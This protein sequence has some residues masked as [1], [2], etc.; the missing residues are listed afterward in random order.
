MK[1]SG[2]A[3]LVGGRVAG[4]VAGLVAALA[5]WMAGAPPASANSV[6]PMCLTDAG[7]QACSGGW[8]TS[9]VL[10]NWA[11]SPLTA[12]SF[13]TPCATETLYSAD[14]NTTV[15]C[16][17]SWPS[18]PD[19]SYPYTMQVELSSPAAWAVP[20]RPPDA[21]GW[22]HRP[23]SVA[24]AGSAFSGIATC[25]QAAYAGPAAASAVITGSCTDNAGKTASATL[26][27]AYDATPPVLSAT[28]VTGDHLVS[29]RWQASAAPAPLASVLISRTP[30]RRTVVE[31]AGSGIF[32]DTQVKD[33]VRY[34]YTI[35]AIDQAGNETVL[36]VSGVPAPRLLEPALGARVTSAP[37]LSW[38]PVRGARYY[39]VQLTRGAREIFSA[40]PSASQLALGRSWWFGG[41][42]YRLR[43]GHYRWYVWPGLGARAA[44][45]YGPLIGQGAFVLVRSGH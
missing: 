44:D 14:T 28:P 16:S 19:I 21:G 11:W 13:T 32:D 38:T 23:L 29:V 10:L 26:T 33:H 34:R 40:W 2:V 41:L 6:T 15:T 42:R 37:L 7:L 24:F 27:I 20:S 35:T 43:P 1:A 22:Y 31:H 5:L 8:Y 17:V 39:N 18:P 36:T 9:P 12:N 4:L 45:H 30:G 3:G 25:T